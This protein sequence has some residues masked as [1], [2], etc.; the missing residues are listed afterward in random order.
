MVVPPRCGA[1]VG[2]RQYYAPAFRKESRGFLLL[3]HQIQFAIAI[4]FD[5]DFDIDFRFA[6]FD[7]YR[8]EKGTAWYS[9]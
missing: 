9:R 5:N 7:C 8:I 3:H 2:Y 1:R 4:D 6:D